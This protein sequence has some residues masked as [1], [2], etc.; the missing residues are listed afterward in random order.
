MVLRRVQAVEGRVLD[1]RGNPVAGAVVRQSGDGPMPTETLTSADGRF[2]LPGVLEGPALV[3][4]ARDGYRPSFSG[5]SASTGTEPPPPLEVTLARTGEP[6]VVTYRTLPPALPIAEEKALALRLLLPYAERV[7]AHGGDPEKFRL[8]VEAAAIDPLATLERME[9]MKFADADY[10][11][12]GRVNLAEAL[13]IENLDEATALLEAGDDA[14]VRAGGYLGICDVRR[15]L[16]AD[17]MKDLLAQAELNVKSVK[18]PPNRMRIEALVADHWLDLGETRRARA[19]LDDALALGRDAA[20][21]TS[22]VNYN[23]GQVA[24]VLA[25]LDL[26][27]ALKALEDLEGV[28]RKSDQ[29]DRSYVFHR[30]FGHIA[31]K[32]AARSPADAER[33]LD[34]LPIGDRTDRY[35]VGACTAMA[36]KDMARARQTRRDADLAGGPGLSVASPGPDGPGDRR[37]RQARRRRPDRRSLSHPRS[38]RRRRR[39]ADVS[40]PRRG[41]GGLAADHR[42]GRAGPAGR[43]PGPHPGPAAGPRRPDRQR[44]GRQRRDHGLAGDD[45]RALRSHAGRPPARARVEEV[46][47]PPVGFRQ[48]LRDAGASWRPWPWP[49]RNGPSRPSRPSPTTPPPAPTRRRPRT[50]PAPTSPRCWPSTATNAGGLCTNISSISGPPISGISD[51]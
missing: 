41:G 46:R 48:G 23:I 33:V 8:F 39:S 7:I 47:D 31:Y 27:A 10:L 43:I 42:A 14:E 32:L 4:A 16:P 2:R 44:R 49:T 5:C 19:L 6:P 30:F 51:H 35:V 15:D 3:F 1:R 40:G 17:Q 37:D 24:E 20:K 12:L 29:V 26:P 22:T 18:S 11:K 21:G 13:A 34:R 28:S 9:S 45:R 38:A 25:R 50:R 36:P